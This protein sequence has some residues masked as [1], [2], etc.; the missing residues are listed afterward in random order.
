MV[1]ITKSHCN[2]NVNSCCVDLNTGKRCSYIVFRVFIAFRTTSLVRKAL[3]LFLGRNS[4]LGLSSGEAVLTKQQAN[5][6]AGPLPRLAETKASKSTMLKD[7][8]STGA[9]DRGFERIP[10]KDGGKRCA[11][12]WVTG[13]TVSPLRGSAPFG[14]VERGGPRTF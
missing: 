12:M 2:Y 13:F 4:G 7:R 3:P 9:R 6:A 5:S 1:T 11:G 10:F 8:A 14:C